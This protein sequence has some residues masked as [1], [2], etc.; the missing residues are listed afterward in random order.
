MA[1]LTA[2]YGILVGPLLRAMFGGSGLAWPEALSG[3]LPRPPSVEQLR[4]VLPPLLVL[5]AVGKGVSSYL[6]SVSLAQFV[7]SSVR[8]WREGVHSRIMGNCPGRVSFEGASYTNHA[9]LAEVSSIGDVLREGLLAGVRDVLQVF[10]LV[11][12]CFVIDWGMAMVVFLVYPIAIVPIAIIGRRMKSTTSEEH[13][14]KARLGA[15]ADD[16]LRRLMLYQM[17]HTVNHARL[18]YSRAGQQHETAVVEARR[19]RALSSPVTETL[20]AVALALGILFTMH[21]LES[22]ALAP[23]HVMSFIA[24]LLLLYQPVKN[25]TRLHGVWLPGQVAH[26]RIEEFLALGQPLPC[27][28]SNEPPHSIECIQVNGLSFGYENRH[29]LRDV[30]ISLTPG[31]LY[32]VAGPNGSG[33]STLLMILSGLMEGWAGTIDVNGQ[34][35]KGVNFEEWRRRIAW[36]GQDGHLASGTIRTNVLLGRSVNEESLVRAAAQSGLQALFS[37][38]RLSW[39][40]PIGDGGVGLSGGSVRKSPYVVHF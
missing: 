18:E 13:E 7:Q 21:R 36:I 39:N 25:L 24:C 16:H 27:G 5:C 20:G 3:F 8:F 40:T 34:P 10:F 6:Y 17:T 15:L 23:E 31:R 11:G 35:L 4:V 12:V 30:T 37:L 14:G 22:S 26:R 29:V 28:G 9:I 19:A 1:L 32:C 38:G 2:S 33:K